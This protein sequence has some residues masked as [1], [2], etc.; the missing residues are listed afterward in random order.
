MR[1]SNYGSVFNSSSGRTKVS[2]YSIR[3]LF[4]CV[5]P[6]SGSWTPPVLGVLFPSC[7]FLGFTDELFDRKE[8][9][10]VIPL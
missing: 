4:L 6:A 7:S 2:D 9:N 8:D 1:H 3:P 5:L 10:S